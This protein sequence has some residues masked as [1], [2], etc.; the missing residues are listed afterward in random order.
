MNLINRKGKHK[1]EKLIN[2]ID[3]WQIFFKT[4][5]T[6]RKISATHMSIGGLHAFPNGV[7]KLAKIRC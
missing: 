3:V 2:T 7:R 5:S 4:P 6:K 1:V